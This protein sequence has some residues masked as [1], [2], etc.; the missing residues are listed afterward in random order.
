M[1]GLRRM[2]Y[3]IRRK[4]YIPTNEIYR[5]YEEHKSKNPKDFIV[6]GDYENGSEDTVY[7]HK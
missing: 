6:E 7:P 2:T 4:Y 1:R 5:A 3:M